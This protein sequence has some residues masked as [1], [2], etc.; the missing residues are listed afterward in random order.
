MTISPKIKNAVHAFRRRL[1]TRANVALLVAIIGVVLI[2][3][4]FAGWSRELAF[5]FVGIVLIVY[6]LL[7]IDLDGSRRRG[8]R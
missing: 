2:T 8:I 4:G 3:L 6:G 1:L 7:F 5:V